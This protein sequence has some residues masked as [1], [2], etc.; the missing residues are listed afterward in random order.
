MTERP[1][2]DQPW[3]ISMG[4]AARWR[5]SP[6]CPSPEDGRFLLE[7]TAPLLARTM[8]SAEVLVLGVT[9][10]IM[11]LAWP[12]HCALTAVDSSADMIAMD[13]QPHSRLPSR[14]VQ[15][16]WQDMPLPDTSMAAAVG[17]ASLN[18]LPGFDDYAAV[19]E[20]IAR[21]LWPGG[22]LAV[23][24]FLRSEAAESCTEVVEAA[25]RGLFAT[26][27]PF[28]LRFAMALAD[29]DGSLDLARIPERF[30]ALVT[31]RGGFAALAGWARADLDRIDVYAN[32]SARINFPT[33]AEL[34]QLVV[35]YFDWQTLR[36]GRY[37][38]AE[39]CPT[40]VLRKR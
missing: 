2:P 38:Q 1:D 25:A 24:M 21:V 26:G 32:S 22:V 13:W 7:A 34:R 12:D 9:P 16:R 33:E 8:P 29:A 10:E 11:S 37:D 40:A 35:P 28:R 18:A 27:V 23:R 36:H 4:T 31:D 20:Q 6:W 14:L 30:D 3:R 19:L 17:D 5:A 39:R 15:A